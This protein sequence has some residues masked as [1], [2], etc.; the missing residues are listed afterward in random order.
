MNQ[1]HFTLARLPTHWAS[2]SGDGIL[3][4]DETLRQR[5]RRARQALGSSNMPDLRMRS[6]RAHAGIWSPKPRVFLHRKRR[7][8][9]WV[10]VA[11]PTPGGRTGSELRFERLSL[12][13]RQIGRQ[14]RCSIARV[15][16][17][18]GTSRA[19]AFSTLSCARIVTIGLAAFQFG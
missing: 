2:S 8:P 12:R 6:G 19:G 1:I 7:S 11:A 14:L 16:R 9:E 5:I 10:L 15:A 13:A 3:P 17:G 4:Y 18:N